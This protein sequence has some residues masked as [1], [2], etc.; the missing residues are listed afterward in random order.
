MLAFLSKLPSICKRGI[1]L[2][3][4]LFM[5]LLIKF[6]PRLL[7]LIFGSSI[8]LISLFSANRVFSQGDDLGIARRKL[9]FQTE[10]LPDHLLYPL[11]M[12]LDK[13][14]L[15]IT[16]PE[17]AVDLQL[18][19]AWRRLEYTER[20]LTDGYQ[21][22]SFSTLTKAYKYYNAGLVQAQT[23]SLRQD[24]R[25]FLVQDTELFEDRAKKLELNFTDSQQQEL[26]RLEFEQ[27]TLIDFFIDSI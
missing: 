10:V 15:E 17:E 19:Y 23:I 12:I 26:M 3:S 25:E 13:V 22:L 20:L 8:V 21:S 14:R 7:F 18:S 24:K 9:Y 27:S 1:I 6:L 4:L 16:P 5:Q 2:L 11:M